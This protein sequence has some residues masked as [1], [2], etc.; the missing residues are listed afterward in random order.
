LIL[1]ADVPALMIVGIACC[2]IPALPAWHRLELRYDA[3]S[4]LRASAAAVLLSL[5][6]LGVARASAVPFKPFIYFRF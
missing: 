1:P 2:L 3:S 4:W 6:V 5:Y